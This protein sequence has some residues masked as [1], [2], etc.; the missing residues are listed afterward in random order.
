[1]AGGKETYKQLLQK[2]ADHGCTEVEETDLGWSAGKVI[3]SE[4][5]LILL[6]MLYTKGKDGS[7]SAAMYYLDRMLGKPK[8]SLNLTNG[9]DLIGKLTDEQLIDKISGLIKGARKGST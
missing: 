3:K 5:V 6:E 7:I 4:R 9:A 1:M 8:E 2:I